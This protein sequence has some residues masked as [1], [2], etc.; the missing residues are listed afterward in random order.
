[1]ISQFL[2]MQAS[3]ENK[4]LAEELHDEMNSNFL[5]HAM[6]DINDAL[7]S[8][9]ALCD[10]EEMENIPK[11]KKYIQRVNSLL[12][13]VQAYQS[14]SAFNIN[15]VLSNMIDVIKDHFKGKAKINY[16]FSEVKSLVKSN[17]L[18]LE[19]ILLYILVELIIT[20][21]DSDLL[22]ISVHLHQKEQDA[23]IAIVKTNHRFT[24]FASEEIGRLIENFTGKVQINPKGQGV[25]IDVRIPLNFRRPKK[26]N[27]TSVTVS[28]IK[29]ASQD[30]VRKTERMSM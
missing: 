25:E 11:V 2:S 4:K 21:Q 7:T 24:D 1:M 14:N 12:N 20:G 5:E 18:Q 13:D 15:H 17:K 3:K 9:L 8:I 30:A 16:T 23:Q 28:G 22:D 6:Y 29:F 10:M 27:F 19:K 26:S